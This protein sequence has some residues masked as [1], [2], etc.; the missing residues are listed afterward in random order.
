MNEEVRE[1][2]LS[3]LRNKL[4]QAVERGKDISTRLGKKQSELFGAS[5]EKATGDGGQLRGAPNGE[6]AEL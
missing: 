4:V 2:E 3:V 6:I 5:P 1:R